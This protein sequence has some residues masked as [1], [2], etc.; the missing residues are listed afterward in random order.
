MMIDLTTIISAIV[1]ALVGMSGQ[2]LEAGIELL[3]ALASGLIKAIPEL[4]KK[5]PEI[6]ASIAGGLLEG[7]GKISDVGLKLVQ[8]LWEGISDAEEWV[9]EKIKGF[10]GKIVKGIKSFFGIH[11]PSTVFAEIGEYMAEG[12]G[13][14]WDDTV[15][16]VIKGMN[17]DMDLE[18]N[19]SVIPNTEEFDEATGTYGS[20]QLA[21]AG[22]IIIPV[23]IGQDRIDEVLVR[24]EQLR[25]YRS[26]G[27]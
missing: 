20:T 16:D 6:I 21:G 14:G 17:N 27:R 18:G 12:L 13:Q 19:V 25:N 23:Y 11:S 10:G 4:V 5:L 24:A 8:G 1:E 2:I 22:D 15:D 7:L 9:I 3:M 26:G